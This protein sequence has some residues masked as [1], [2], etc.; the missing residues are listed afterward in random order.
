MRVNKEENAGVPD[1]LQPATEKKAEHIQK[2][3]FISIKSTSHESSYCHVL[4]HKTKYQKARKPDRDVGD[5]MVEIRLISPE[6]KE[7]KCY[8]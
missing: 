5:C 2:P 7:N 8:S 1:V 4:P 6:L 3:T